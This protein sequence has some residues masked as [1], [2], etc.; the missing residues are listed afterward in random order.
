MIVA[1]GSLECDRSR[2]RIAAGPFLLE[3][4]WLDSEVGGMQVLIILWLILCDNFLEELFSCSGWDGVW[5]KKRACGNGSRIIYYSRA[6]LYKGICGKRLALHLRN[7]TASQW[8][9][10]YSSWTLYRKGA[11][12]CLL[13]GCSSFRGRGRKLRWGIQVCYCDTLPW[14]Y[15]NPPFILSPKQWAEK[16]IVEL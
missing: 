5:Q 4:F 11:I 13:R 6:S 9:H 8:G 12:S 15:T 7:R 10:V 3:F 16:A 2:V 1:L 14:W